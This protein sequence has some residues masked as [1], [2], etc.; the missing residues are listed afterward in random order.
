MFEVMNLRSSFDH[1]TYEQYY[2]VDVRVGKD[3][4]YDLANS[5]SEED[6]SKLYTQLGKELFDKI[7]ELKQGTITEDFISLRNLN[8][9][10]TLVDSLP[11]FCS[12]GPV[13]VSTVE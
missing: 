1:I 9:K 7:H 5:L 11:E 2:E 3:L 6:K 8:G 10:S 12:D 13:M 4:S